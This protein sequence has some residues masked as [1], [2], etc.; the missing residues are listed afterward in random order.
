METDTV[1]F[2]KLYAMNMPKKQKNLRTGLQEKEA[3]NRKTYVI[4]E[5]PLFL[6]NQSVYTFLIFS[7]LVAS[8]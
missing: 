7:S 5:K 2:C 4:L 1:I 3:F 8:T 6:E